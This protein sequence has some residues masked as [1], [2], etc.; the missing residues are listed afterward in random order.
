MNNEFLAELYAEACVVLGPDLASV[1]R[2]AAV[3]GEDPA[4]FKKYL[5]GEESPTLDRV[6]RWLTMWQF[7]GYRPIRILI[8]AQG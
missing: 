7:M 1:H 8:A 6:H 4:L 5:R 3:F 2:V